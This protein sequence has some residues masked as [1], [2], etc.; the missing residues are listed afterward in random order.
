MEFAIILGACVIFAG[1][2][3]VADSLSGIAKALK[4]DKDKDDG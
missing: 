1:L 3:L 4:L 2:F